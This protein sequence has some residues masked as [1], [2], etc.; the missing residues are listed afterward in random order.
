MAKK[1]VSKTKAP[2]AKSKAKPKAKKAAT[3]SKPKAKR[4]PAKAR[5]APTADMALLNFR[6][7]KSEIPTLRRRAEQVAGGNLSALI[8]FAISKLRASDRIPAAELSHLRKA[9]KGS[10]AKSVKKLNGKAPSALS[11]K[12]VKKTKSVDSHPEF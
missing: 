11:T 2:K 7:K 10:P 6:Y 4:A 1:K 12:K 8:R 5:R 9:P 3:K